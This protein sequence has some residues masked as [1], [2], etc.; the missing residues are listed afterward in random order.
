MTDAEKIAVYQKGECPFCGSK[1]YYPGPCGGMSQNVQCSECGAELNIN[2][3]G[4]LGGEILSE[5]KCQGCKNPWV[6]HDPN[7]GKCL[8][9]PGVWTSPA[10]RRTNREVVEHYVIRESA[11]KTF[12]RV[13]WWAKPFIAVNVAVFAYGVYQL[14]QIAHPH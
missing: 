7:T 9:D 12:L 8:F 4:F 3:A 2:H 1:K 6:N 11:W 14:W 5:P 10:K 13:H